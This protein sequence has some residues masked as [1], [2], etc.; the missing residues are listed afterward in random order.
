MPRRSCATPTSAVSIR[1][2]ICSRLRGNGDCNSCT[3]RQRM[4][5]LPPKLSRYRA[6]A[7]LLLK[8]GRSTLIAEPDDLASA[9]APEHESVDPDD[10]GPEALA[11]DLEKL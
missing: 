6:V 7:A 4:S 9:L 3:G 5:L 10:P 1:T 2:Q 11:D 8:Y